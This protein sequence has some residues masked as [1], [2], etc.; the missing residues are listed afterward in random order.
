VSGLVQPVEQID[1][2]FSAFA[3]NAAALRAA[4]GLL[5]DF[6][7]DALSADFGAKRDT[8]IWA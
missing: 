1:N 6:A 3:G 5:I 2:L 4:L 8:V 7:W